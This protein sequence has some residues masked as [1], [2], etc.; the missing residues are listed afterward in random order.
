MTYPGCWRAVPLL[1]AVSVCLACAE[2]S[3]Q[4]PRSLFLEETATAAIQEAPALKRA[5]T[6]NRLSR[7]TPEVLR[8]LNA[9]DGNEITCRITLDDSAEYLATVRK[10]ETSDEQYRVLAGTLTGNAA[11]RIIL[12]TDG[13]Q[14]AGSA[15][16]EGRGSFRITPRGT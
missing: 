10:L 3:A 11:G 4:S 13:Q 9:G 1:A 15:E 5:A 6:S 2:V 16:I 7:V 12:V 14:L 8:Q